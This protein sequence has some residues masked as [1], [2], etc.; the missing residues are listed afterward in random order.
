M[1]SAT[2]KASLQ[3][4]EDS[5]VLYTSHG[6]TPDEDNFLYVTKRAS[7]YDPPWGIYKGAPPYFTPHERQLAYNGVAVE[8]DSTLSASLRSEQGRRG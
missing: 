8:S 5:D 3:P 6:D 4:L 2:K 7:K 1:V